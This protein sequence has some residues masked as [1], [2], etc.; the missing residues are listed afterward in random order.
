[1]PFNE[2]FIGGNSITIVGCFEDGTLSGM[3]SLAT[4]SVP[5]GT[6]GWIEDV[7]VDQ[8][9]RGR[10]IG[11]QLVQRLVELAQ[12]QGCTD[13]LLFTGHHRKPAIALYESIGF[14]RKESFLYIM[15]F[16]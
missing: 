6:K 2:L 4:N 1:V 15:E 9:Q 7:V 11:R 13:L 12:V 3:A 14:M 5:S 16:R 10:G 8:N